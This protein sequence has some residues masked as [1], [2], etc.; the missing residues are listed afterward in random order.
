M[1]KKIRMKLKEKL[2]KIN[3]DDRGSAF[4]FVIIGVM[5]VSI[6]G[7]TVLSL[8]TNY[9][10]A[11]IVDHYSTD[12]FYQ[13]EGYLSEV[14]SGIEELAGEINENAYLEVMENYTSTVAATPAPGAT[15]SPASL[16]GKKYEYGKKYL[17]GIVRELNDDPVNPQIS[18]ANDVFK[19]IQTDKVTP[20][21]TVKIDKIKKMTTNPAALSSTYTNPDFLQYRFNYDSDSKKLSLTIRGLLIE[22]TDDADYHTNIQTDINIGVPDYAFEG[23]STFDQLKHF[24]SISDDILSVGSGGSMN[25]S[26]SGSV[27]SGTAKQ[28]FSPQNDDK[29]SGIEILPSSTVTFNSKQIISRGNLNIFSGSNVTMNGLTG[30]TSLGDLWLKN[31]VLR[32]PMGG[33]NLHSEVDIRDNAYILDDTSIEDDNSILNIGGNYYGYSYNEQNTNTAGSLRSDYSSAILIN[34]KNTKLTSEHL[35]KLVLAGRTFVQRNENK[36]DGTYQ[37]AADDIMMGESLAVKSNQIAYLVPEKYI[38]GEHNPLARDEVDADNILASIKLEQLKND[39]NIWSYVDQHTDASGNYDKLI[40]ANFSNTGNYVYLYLNF[41]SES[42]ANKYFSNYYSGMDETGE[43]NKTNLDDKATTYISMA[44]NEGMKISPALYL[45]AGNIIHNYYAVGGS[46]QQPQNYYDSSGNPNLA[47]L[48]DGRAKM[49]NYLGLQKT[50]LPSGSD[51]ISDIRGELNSPSSELVCDVILNIDTGGTDTS[52]DNC[53]KRNGETLPNDGTGKV[54]VTVPG[55]SDWVL[56]FDNAN[57]TIPSNI[58]S[59]SG[60]RKGLILC[61]K[62]VT[63]TSDF[64]GL[65]IAGGKVSIEAGG[66]YKAN[67]AMIGEILEMIRSNRE[68]DW[69]KYFRCLDDEEKSSVN[70]ADCISY[71]NWERNSN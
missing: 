70:V 43:A 8:A 18:G 21:A 19:N 71:E 4:V 6:V 12:N 29:D 61:A 10:T 28:P 25:A 16:T 49:K 59:I 39:S 50:L 64:E 37:D 67:P 65:I 48:E 32:Q 35:T 5:F 30:L 22:Y 9:V 58:S 42:E 55:H 68:K 11:V 53:F 56:Y 57:C 38:V 63:V 41:A 34:G 26:V 40:T 2:D 20:W 60:A 33:T 3:E 1:W 23:N 14:R 17:A 54:D 51:G 24:I 52:A 7:A 31:V 47:L 27:Y 45:I 36:G 62:D 15:A 69:W 44:D 46:K 13:T 66:S